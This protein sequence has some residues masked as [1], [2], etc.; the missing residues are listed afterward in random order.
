MA[1][2]AKTI[3]EV[4]DALG[5]YYKSEGQ[6]YDSKF[7]TLCE[8]SGYEDDDDDPEVFLRN[9]IDDLFE[10]I[11]GPGFNFPG[12][13]NGA[14]RNDAIRSILY[15]CL[16]NPRRSWEAAATLPTCMLCLLFTF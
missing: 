7:Q 12:V 16:E 11:S 1:R 4:C 2:P 5:R 8:E 6:K 14:G 3:K 9:T 13:D 15:Q 10:D